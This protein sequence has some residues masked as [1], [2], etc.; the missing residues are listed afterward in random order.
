MDRALTIS[1]GIPAFNQGGYLEET[2]V[3]LLEQTRP[4]DEIVVSDQYSTDETPDIIAKY[5]KQ[6]RGVKPPPGVNLAGQYHFTLASQTSDW[7]TLLSS[8]DVAAPNFCEVLE[9]GARRRDDAVLVRA[10]W[11]NM[12]A[13][14]NRLSK[15]YLFTAKPVTLPPETLLEQREGPRASFAAFAVSR[16]AY[17][18][19][20]PILETLES[21]ADW[22][23]FLQLA[24]FGSFIY[25]SELISY[26]RIAEG[27]DKF[28]Q[29]VGMWVRD[30]Q[31]IFGDVLPLAAQRLNMADTAWIGVQSRKNFR[32]YIAS[33]S[34]RYAPEERGEIAPLFRDWAESTGSEKLLE[35]F[36][37]GGAIAQE[38]GVV[39]RMK[40]A[41]RPTARKVRAHFQRG[42]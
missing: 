16:E 21:L 31:R 11:W 9:R 37:A 22:A 39:K 1:V 4:P 34:E 32:R 36:A 33:A 24:P 38:G 5:G 35:T 41:I 18:K 10:G 20:G 29:R 8:D 7:I 30:E 2:I 27:P 19:S 23:L 26:Y 3:S 14:G 25:E 6:V 40:D 15:E 28:R 42:S 17:A 13:A 12:D